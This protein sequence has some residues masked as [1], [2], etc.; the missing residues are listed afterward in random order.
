[1]PLPSLQRLACCAACWTA[2][3]CLREGDGAIGRGDHGVGGALA[4]HQVETQVGGQVHLPGQAATP[5]RH[6][7]MFRWR[8][9]W[10]T[11]ARQRVELDL[12]LT[13]VHSAA[14]SSGKASRYVHTFRLAGILNT[15]LPWGAGA[16]PAVRGRGLTSGMRPPAARTA[17]LTS[18][19][20]R[21]R[22]TYS[23]PLVVY[24][25]SS[26]SRPSALSFT[27]SSTTLRSD[28][29]VCGRSA[30]ERWRP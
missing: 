5:A 23:L 24:S 3:P 20:A 26:P 16:Q 7:P 10:G 21:S 11:R 22:V 25:S 14:R 18:A 28:R 29:R 6:T 15:S 2:R 4:V 13:H 8:G 17:A 27:T 1:M 30:E 9:R 19:A 12:P